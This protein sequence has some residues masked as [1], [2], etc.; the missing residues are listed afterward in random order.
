MNKEFLTDRQTERQI[1][2]DKDFLIHLNSGH[3][4]ELMCTDELMYSPNDN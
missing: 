3:L 1:K 4:R 2:I